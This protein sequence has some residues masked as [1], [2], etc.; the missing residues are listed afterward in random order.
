MQQSYTKNKE[1]GDFIKQRRQNISPIQVGLP[2]LGRRRTPGLRR[3]EVSSLAGI[4][5][6]WYTWLEQGRDIQVSAQ[7]L[8]SIGHALQ[9]SDTEVSYIL[10]LAGFTSEQP[11]TT[12]SMTVSSKLQHVLDRLD[13]AP[14]VILNAYWDIVAWNAA[15]CLVFTDFEQL[16]PSDR[17]LIKL[18]FLNR[19][20]QNLHLNW[21]SKAKLL[22]SQ[23]RL[24]ISDMIDDK[25]VIQFTNSMMK[26]SSEFS[27]WWKEHLIQTEA[28][29]TKII[30]HPQVGI[31]QFEHT[32]YTIND[33]EQKNLKLYINTPIKD[34]DTEVKIKDLI[35]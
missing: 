22:L 20:F 19:P 3:E 11:E 32:S 2:Q 5:V 10:D 15:A 28:P 35:H 24:S 12:P 27:Q 23:F 6:S 21:E 33:N 25:K 17:N 14:S 34:D 7:V 18:I 8:L 16:K 26:C 4:G 29:L 30:S 31:L 13:P 1:L 9:L